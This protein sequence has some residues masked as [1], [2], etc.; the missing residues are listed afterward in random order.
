MFYTDN[1][2][3]GGVGSK[4]HLGLKFENVIVAAMSFSKSRYA[5]NR[6]IQDGVYELTRY[7][8]LQD[9]TIIGGAGKLFNHFKSHYNWVKIYSY[10][11]RCWSTGN[12]YRVLNMVDITS[13]YAPRYTY[14][15]TFGKRFSRVMF[16]KHKL[17]DIL[18]IF[19]NDKSEL[20]NMIDNGY[21]PV[22]DC[23]NLLFEIHNVGKPKL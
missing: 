14:T 2:I 3:Q 6:T 21:Y 11:D 19:D 18:P 16:Q 10:A 22:Y 7:C 8:S 23:G 9:H 17:K 15:K 1:H 5:T 12:L 13:N 20:D 4:V